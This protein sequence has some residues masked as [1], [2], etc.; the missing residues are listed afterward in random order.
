MYSS[1]ANQNYSMPTPQGDNRFGYT[2]AGE[3]QNNNAEDHFSSQ[4]NSKEDKAY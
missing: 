2:P 1:K 3:Q 4:Y